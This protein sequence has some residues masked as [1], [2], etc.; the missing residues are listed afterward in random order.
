MH[1]IERAF[2]HNIK[3]TKPAF[4]S[5]YAIK[6]IIHRQN[7]PKEKNLIETEFDL[8]TAHDLVRERLR[9]KFADIGAIFSWLFFFCAPDKKVSSSSHACGVTLKHADITMTDEELGTLFEITKP[10]EPSLLKRRPAF[11]FLN[12]AAWWEGRYIYV[13]ISNTN[14]MAEEGAKAFSEAHKL[15]NK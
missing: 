9:E 5:N 11:S 3:R 7:P 4:V 14:E 13:C 6:C 2:L 15:Q 1:K 10:I 12:I 8:D